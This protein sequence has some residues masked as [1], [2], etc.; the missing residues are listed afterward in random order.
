VITQFVDIS[1]YSTVLVMPCQSET[2]CA[3]RLGVDDGFLFVPAL[4][5]D[6]FDVYFHPRMFADY[7]GRDICTVYIPLQ[8]WEAFLNLMPI[9]D[10]TWRLL[11]LLDQWLQSDANY[12]LFEYN[13]DQGLDD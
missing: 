12:I 10:L 8:D 2:E 13:I 9:N 3:K 6:D 11:K 1:P 4:L 7:A 5:M